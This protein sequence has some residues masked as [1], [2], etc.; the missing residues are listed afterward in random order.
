MHETALVRDVVRQIVEFGQAAGAVRVTRA[1][2]WLG[3][4]S[5]LSADHFREHFAIAARDTAAEHAALE[6]EVSGDPHHPQAQHVLLE[7]IDLD[8]N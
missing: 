6:I 7:S 4:F 1:K 2:I 3:A 5:H 8:E